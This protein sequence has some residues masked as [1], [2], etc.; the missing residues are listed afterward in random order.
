MTCWKYSHSNSCEENED[1]KFINSFT[2]KNLKRCPNALC[3]LLIQKID[4]G[5]EKMVCKC[6]CKFCFDCGS[7]IIYIQSIKTCDCGNKRDER[8]LKRR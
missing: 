2:I 6:G 8:R 5:C 1:N 4:G 7:E 3:G